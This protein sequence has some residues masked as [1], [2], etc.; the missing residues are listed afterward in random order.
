[1][2]GDSGKR[3]RVC[4]DGAVH[5]LADLT[6]IAAELAER[7]GAPAPDVIVDQTSETLSGAWVTVSIFAPAVDQADAPPPSGICRMCKRGYSPTHDRNAPGPTS[8][9][10]FTPQ[11]TR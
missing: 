9:H 5:G 8:R 11:A 10:P 4:G 7:I 3:I 1:M 2:S 6:D